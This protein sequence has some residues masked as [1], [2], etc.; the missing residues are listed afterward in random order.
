MEHFSCAEFFSL[1]DMSGTLFQSL[2][3]DICDNLNTSYIVM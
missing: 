2:C 3:T 1:A